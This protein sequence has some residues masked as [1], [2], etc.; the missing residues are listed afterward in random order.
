MSAVSAIKETYDG[1]ALLR[2][3]LGDEEP[4][5]EMVALFRAER[6]I[7]GNNGKPCPQNKEPNWWFRNVA[8]P[9]AQYIRR[10]LELKSKMKMRLLID[11]DLHMCASCGCALPLKVWVPSHHLRA[12]LSKAVIDKTPDYCWMRKEFQP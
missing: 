2:D 5:H 8:D 3:W 11:D 10:Q 4:V 9:I 1:M 7:Q 6:C 12:H